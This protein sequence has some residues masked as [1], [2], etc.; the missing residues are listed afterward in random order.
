MPIS[1]NPGTL[2]PSTII[3]EQT[4][5]AKRVGPKKRRKEEVYPDLASGR[6]GK[7]PGREEEVASSWTE[8]SP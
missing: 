7:G 2:K 5:A 8:C 4:H 6:V 3:S 1:R